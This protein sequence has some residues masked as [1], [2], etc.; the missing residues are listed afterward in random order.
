MNM[1]KF[2]IALTAGLLACACSQ[3][4]YATFSGYAQGG[5]YS[6]TANLDGVRTPREEIAA[7][8]DS[9]L[10]GIDFSISGYN[11]NSLLSRRNRGEMI[12]PDRFFREIGELSE[13][14]MLETDGAFDV[15]GGPIFDA[16]GF[17]FTS[18]SLPPLSG[19]RWPCKRAE[20][21][22]Y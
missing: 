17:G 2:V 18:D 9:L 6:V 14:Y 7:H 3:N 15:Y 4:R 19:F 11:K 10:T 21:I 22:K 5:V 13:K 16:W 8:I 20:S 1:R 12:A